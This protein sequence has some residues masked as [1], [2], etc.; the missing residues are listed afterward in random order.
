MKN[1]IEK[2]RHTLNGPLDYSRVSHA[3]ADI[4]GLTNEEYIKE[5]TKYIAAEYSTK[6]KSSDDIVKLL[7]HL[8][9]LEYD[10][11]LYKDEE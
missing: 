6:R 4:V 7:E 10:D 9:D 3:I 1:Q 11:Q 2:I 8:V 5:I